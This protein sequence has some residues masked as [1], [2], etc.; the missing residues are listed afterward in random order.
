MQEDYFGTS[1]VQQNVALADDHLFLLASIS[2][3][4]TA[5]ALLQL[6]E[7]G[8]FDLDDKINDHLSFNVSIPNHSTDITFRMLLTHT[9]GIADGSALDG[10]Y[11][12]GEDSPIVLGD[13][14]ENYLS[15]NGNLYNAN[16]NFHDFAPGSQHEYSNTCLL[17]TSPSPRD[18]RQSRMPSSA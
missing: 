1:Q 2:K 11:Y 15:P 8:L 17:Y 9:S 3:V 13:F 18:K 6:Y 12:Y 5:T 16:E 4:V 10:Q 7:D 14:L